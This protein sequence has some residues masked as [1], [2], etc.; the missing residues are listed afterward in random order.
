MNGSDAEADSILGNVFSTTGSYTRLN[1]SHSDVAQA[2]TL[3]IGSLPYVKLPWI[4]L[5][6]LQEDA[7]IDRVAP[8]P[9]SRA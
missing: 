5:R 6:S 9:T 1:P 3:S 2:M 8:Q 4:D 7:G